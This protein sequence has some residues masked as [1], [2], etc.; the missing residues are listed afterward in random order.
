MTEPTEVTIE[1]AAY[2]TSRAVMV[3]VL[4]PRGDGT[5]LLAE[6]PALANLDAGEPES[7]KV[8]EGSALIVIPCKTMVDPC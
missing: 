2:P 3:G 8:E 1:V 7:F 6:Q 5:W 4:M